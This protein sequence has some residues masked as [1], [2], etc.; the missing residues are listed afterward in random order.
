MFLFSIQKILLKRDFHSQGVKPNLQRT[1]CRLF[2][3]VVT[4]LE[5]EMVSCRLILPWTMIFNYKL[6]DHSSFGLAWL[7]VLSIDSSW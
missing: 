3:V 5:W 4:A 1:N 7:D 2:Y 6:F